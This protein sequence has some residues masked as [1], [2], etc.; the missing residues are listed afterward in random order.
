[1]SQNSQEKNLCRSLFF[2]KI[3][4]RN[5]HYGALNGILQAAD[6]LNIYQKIQKRSLKFLL[7]NYYKTILQ[8]L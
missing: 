4:G 6:V 7:N 2:N 5:L 1:M 3:A 8:L